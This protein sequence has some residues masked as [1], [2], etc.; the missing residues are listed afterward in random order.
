MRYH[1]HTEDGRTYPDDEGAELPDLAA[2][3][4]EASKVLGEFLKEKPRELWEHDCL[5]LRVADGAGLTLFTLNLSVT[6]SA[7]TSGRHPRV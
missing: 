2:A 6:M 1:F 5:S 4:I 7:A 3:C